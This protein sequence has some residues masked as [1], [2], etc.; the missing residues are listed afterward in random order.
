[1]ITANIETI[2]PAIA[3][4]MLSMNKNN[5]RSLSKYK[6]SLYAYEMQNNAW[7]TNGEPIVF[8]EDGNLK[9]G[10]HRLTAIVESD[11]TL[12]M[13][14]VRG[15]AKDVNIFDIGYARTQSQMARSEGLP[16]NTCLLG[17]V[18]MLFQ[19]KNTAA[20][21][22]ISLQYVADHKEL[23]KKALEIVRLC[24]IH[25]RGP[26]KRSPVLLAVY[27]FMRFEILSESELAIFFKVFNAMNPSVVEEAYKVEMSPIFVANKQIV[28][29]GSSSP[30]SFFTRSMIIG[31]IITQAL[32]DFKVG[33]KRLK[34]YK[35][36]GDTF[37]KMIEKIR[38]IDGISTKES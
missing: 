30:Y 37:E 2:T 24:N 31:E 36:D 27:M 33:K 34:A 1:M 15:V 11:V 6:V 38:F 22:K 4:G 23:L 13:L 18:N 5:Y 9:N 19:S 29:V 16:S 32:L 10:Q 8:D 28:S 25:N 3:R 35:Q 17:A 21:K 7:E 26:A 14:V 12:P 20:S